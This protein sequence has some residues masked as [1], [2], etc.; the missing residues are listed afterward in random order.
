MS[1]SPQP[2]ADLFWQ[3]SNSE[4][5]AINAALPRKKRDSPEWEILTAITNSTSLE[6]IATQVNNRRQQLSIAL[7]YGWER[8]AAPEDDTNP[9]L[10]PAIP[11][12]TV[13]IHKHQ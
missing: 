1:N 2:V 8:V 9:F 7:R 3:P 11:R 13:V 6:E 5:I 12:P 10:G 4:L